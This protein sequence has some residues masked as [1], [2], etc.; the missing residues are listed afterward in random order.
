MQRHTPRLACGVN[1]DGWRLKMEIRW[2]EDFIVLARE[3]HFS[4]AADAQNV[5]QPTFSRRIKL[6]EE[7]MG[8]TL[9][10]RQTLPLSLTPAGEEF[11]ALCE[12]IT[13]RVRL[14]RDRLQSIAT[15][16]ARRILLAAPQS[17]VSNFLPGWLDQ[18]ALRPSISP[19]LRATSWLIGDYLHGLERGECDLA[20]LYWPRGR[21]ALDLEMSELKYLSLGEER[22][23]P[24]SAPDAEGRSRFSL[25]GARRQPQPLIAFH[26]RGLMAA[27]LEAHLGRQS[28]PVYLTTLNESVQA[29]NIRELVVQ[30][31]GLGWLPQRS[32]IT[33]M[34]HGELVRAGDERWDVPLDLRLY[35]RKDSRHPGLPGLWQQL[36]ATYSN[37]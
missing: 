34:A 17:L 12:Q 1:D 24:V 33:P 37:A 18:H 13:E 15:D 25:P 28:G 8:T 31:Y 27:A 30:G 36:E 19:Y 6:L 26:P 5:T 14:T 23:V 3:R 7:E 22:L 21:I 32:V 16:E 20:L 35:A 4:R 10:N 9:I 29:T 2:L 11:L